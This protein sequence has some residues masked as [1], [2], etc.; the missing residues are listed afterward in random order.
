MKVLYLK[1]IIN[2]FET[3]F[4]R[5]AYDDLTHDIDDD[6]ETGCYSIALTHYSHIIGIDQ[7]TA[8]GG[9]YVR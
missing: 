1:V 5:L 2:G 7:S 9:S 3:L 4:S 6:A 8:N